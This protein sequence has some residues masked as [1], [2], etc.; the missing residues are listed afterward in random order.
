M[1]RAGIQNGEVAHEAEGG[2]G[3]DGDA[4]GGAG[5]GVEVPLA[6][7][8]GQPA[9]GL[10][11]GAVGNDFDVRVAVQGGLVREVVR[12]AWRW[13]NLSISRFPA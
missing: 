11:A 7:A 10:Q 9:D 1:W 6:V 4:V 8:R 3:A 5:V 13:R 12:S 2:V